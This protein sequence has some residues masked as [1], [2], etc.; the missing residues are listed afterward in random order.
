MLP[1]LTLDMFLQAYAEMEQV[2]WDIR[3][4]QPAIVEAEAAGA[5]ARKSVLDMGCGTGD[6]A[7]F[8]ASKGYN[9]TGVD[10][11]PDAI[12]V[13]R[14]RVAAAG[15]L[16]GSVELIVG[17]VFA[18]SLAPGSFDTL[19]DCAMFHCV[20]DDEAQRRYIATV[21]PLIRPGGKLVMFA[22]SAANP[23][24][25]M[26]PRR[27]SEAHARALWEEGGLWAVDAVTFPPMWR[28]NFFSGEK[29]EGKGILLLA[30]R[31]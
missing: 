26:G 7:V 28:F 31:L 2:P 3:A 8:L 9:V 17:D 12:R 4:P 14:E 24:P 1:R 10:I 20:G 23:N 5:F 6:A 25:W 16:A 19:L 21:S 22:F 11:V 18:H 29:V 15:D 27:I 30:T 13:A